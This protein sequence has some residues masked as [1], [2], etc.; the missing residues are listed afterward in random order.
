MRGWGV[1]FVGVEATTMKAPF[2]E[3]TPWNE[4]TIEP[5]GNNPKKA[6]VKFLVRHKAWSDMKKWLV[7]LP[8]KA[9]MVE[10]QLLQ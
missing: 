3:A 6:F 10:K 5:F 7:D 8:T 4:L 9:E 1:R 2:R